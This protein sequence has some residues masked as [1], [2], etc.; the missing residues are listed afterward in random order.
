MKAKLS[1]TSFSHRYVFEVEKNG[2][3]Y[4]VV[5]FLNQKGKFIDDSISFNGKELG[6]EGEEGQIREDIVS[7]LDENWDGIAK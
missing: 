2:K 1:H 5:I 3:T 7:Y 6:S 4:D